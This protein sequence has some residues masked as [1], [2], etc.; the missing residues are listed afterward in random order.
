M[1]A[2]WKYILIG[3]F[4][5]GLIALPFFAV[6]WLGLPFWLSVPLVMLSLGGVIAL[7][8]KKGET[9][10]PYRPSP[11]PSFKSGLP[12]TISF[13]SHT[14][15]IDTSGVHVRRQSFARCICENFAWLF[16]SD[17]D[18][19]HSEFRAVRVR[20]RYSVYT[21]EGGPIP[22]LTVTV[23][24][25]HQHAE[26]KDVLLAEG[27]WDLDIHAFS[28]QSLEP[29]KRLCEDAGRACSLPVLEEGILNETDLWK[30]QAEAKA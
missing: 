6:K 10:I 27:D 4:S 21:G 5:I 12:I 1:R 18:A 2:V 3:A 9:R 29:L 13:P 22:V 7:A 26:K 14:A 25:V 24:L 20:G 28:I 23:T 16:I 8:V 11:L 17:F 30:A 15:T 19:P